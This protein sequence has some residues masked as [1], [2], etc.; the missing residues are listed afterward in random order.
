MDNL[1]IPMIPGQPTCLLKQKKRSLPSNVHTEPITASTLA[2]YRRLI[3]LLLP[4][5]YPDRFYKDS[6][7]DI[8]DSSLAR[9]AIWQETDA[10]KSSHISE[11][12][13]FHGNHTTSEKKVA[14]GIQCRLE[15]VPSSPAG[16][17][18]L[19]IQ[20]VGVL[21]PYRQLGIATYL[22]EDII[23][24]IIDHYE[25]VTSVY[26]HVWE[27]NTDALEW[28][29]QR[30]FSIEKEIL[31][32]YYRRLKPTGARIVRR[33]ITIEDHVAARERHIKSA[34]IPQDDDANVAI[35]KDI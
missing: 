13:A 32:G 28:Y 6:V 11:I 18:Q 5:R 4:I 34:M 22:L 35:V 24:T 31:E 7:A 19:Y 1:S 10:H 9:V 17:S 29:N 30:G 15:D 16:E 8:T 26:A 25:N 23:S 3:T 12:P 2:S 21:A 33:G 27:A 20:T 14:G